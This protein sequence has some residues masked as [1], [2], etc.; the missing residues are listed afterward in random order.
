MKNYISVFLNVC[1]E[2]FKFEISVLGDNL[3]IYGIFF[4]YFVVFIMFI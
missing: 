2:C 4:C 3:K 1:F